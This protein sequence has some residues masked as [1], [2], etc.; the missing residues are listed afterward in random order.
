[1]HEGVR[2]NKIIVTVGSQTLAIKLKRLFAHAG[3][4]SR[5]VKLDNSL[6]MNGCVHGL[7]ISNRDL[8]SAVVIMRENK[9]VY[10]IHER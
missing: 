4:P 1:M 5:P 6:K 9:I 8:F 2:M 7:E 10:W 3:I